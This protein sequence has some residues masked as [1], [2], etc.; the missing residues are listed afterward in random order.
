MENATF[1]PSFS[2]IELEELMSVSFH[3]EKNII[4]VLTSKFNIKKSVLKWEI[5]F[6]HRCTYFGNPSAHQELP[7]HTGAWKA[8]VVI[9]CFLRFSFFRMLN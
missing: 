6:G 4:Q 9:A 1:R 7:N 8:K 2:E 5:L 3:T